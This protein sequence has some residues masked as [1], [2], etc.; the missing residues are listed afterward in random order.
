MT[1]ISEIYQLLF[2]SSI[3]F[4]CY[5]LGNLI[6]KTFLRFKLKAD[7]RFNISNIEKILFWISTAI[8]FTYIF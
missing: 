4:M 6:I 5:V 3:V 8:F 2:I 7:T 1:I